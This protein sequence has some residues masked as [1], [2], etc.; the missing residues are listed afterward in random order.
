VFGTILLAFVL[1]S[2]IGGFFSIILL[3]VVLSGSSSAGTFIVVDSIVSIASLIVLTPF[4][5]IVNVVIAI[6]MRVRKEGLDLEILARNVDVPAH[7]TLVPPVLTWGSGFPTLPP[8]AP[9]PS[10]SEPPRS[11]GPP[12]P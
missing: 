6:D 12:P 8:S 2:V 3:G 1:T 5:A 10:S 7:P 4:S 11:D 9:P